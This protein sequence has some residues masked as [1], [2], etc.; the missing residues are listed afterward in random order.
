MRTLALA[1]PADPRR[2]VARSVLLAVALVAATA[3][4]FTFVRFYTAKFERTTGEAAWLWSHNRVAADQPEAFLLA[5]DFDV[6]PARSY[7]RIRVAADPQYT[8]WFNG[9]EVGGRRSDGITLDTYDVTAMARERGNRVVIAVRSPRGVGGVLATI[10]LAP[11]RQ[12]WI[13]TDASWRLYREWNESIIRSG[14]T[15][16]GETPRVL[17]SPPFGRWNYPEEREGEPYPSRRAFRYPRETIRYASWLP[18]IEVKSGVAVAGRVPAEATAFDFGSTYGRIAV[19]VKPGPL[20][21]IPIRFASER[22]QLEEDGL[23]EALVVGEGET[24]VVSPQR[25]GFR[26]LIVY[27]ETVEAWAIT[28]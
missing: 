12:N 18:R 9:I 28:E 27:D 21:A 6:P 8:L 22:E 24:T 13:V 5:R 1:E 15:S 20:R 26:Y 2:F 16:A 19:R 17:G 10:D 14:A 11:M 3:V 25:R 4:I 7:V 23:I